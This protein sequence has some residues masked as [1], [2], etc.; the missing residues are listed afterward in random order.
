MSGLGKAYMIEKKETFV[1]GST[2]QRVHLLHREGCPHMQDDV[3]HAS[4]KKSPEEAMMEAKKQYFSS[5][6][7]CPHCCNN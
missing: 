7:F 3:Y 1:D 4:Y 6:E 5:V 2:G